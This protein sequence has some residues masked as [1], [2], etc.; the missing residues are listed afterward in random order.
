M[1]YGMHVTAIK[2]LAP[3]P[4]LGDDDV[5]IG[6]T[7][8]GNEDGYTKY[9][10]NPTRNHSWDMNSGET[11]D[12]WNDS[13]LDDGDIYPGNSIEVYFNSS[14]KISVWDADRGAD[15]LLGIGALTGTEAVAATR[16]ADA[17]SGIDGRGVAIL[18]LVQKDGR[19]QIHYQ[20]WEV[21]ETASPGN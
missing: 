17:S 20:A 2:C 7:L 5:Y 15:D 16:A 6:I 8:D 19:Y 1:K 10:S 9:P 14:F 4:G 3:S 18:G 13:T 12:L 21:A 11:I